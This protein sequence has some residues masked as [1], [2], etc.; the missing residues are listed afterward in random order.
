MTDLRHTLDI[1]ARGEIFTS[2]HFIYLPQS[3]EKYSVCTGQIVASANHYHKGG[4][5]TVK[6]CTLC[7]MIT[8]INEASSLFDK[9]EILIG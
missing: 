1:T 6:L 5:R 3:A 4:A 8:V 7:G 2:R 9:V